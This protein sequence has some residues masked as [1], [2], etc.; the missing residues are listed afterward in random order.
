MIMLLSELLRLPRRLSGSSVSRLPVLALLAAILPIWA[1]AGS[2]A[3]AKDAPKLATNQ[4]YLE[5]INRATVL[6]TGN[7][8]AVFAFVFASLPDT[9]K[10][11]PTENYYYFTFIH[12][13]ATFT[14]N[15]RLDAAD[16]DQGFL[17][18]AYFHEY[19][20]WQ[21]GEDPAYKKLGGADG[22]RVEKR[23]KLAY[24]AEFKG[25]QVL[26]E[27]NDL[28][29]V[30]PPEGFLLANERYIGPIYDESGVQFFLV[31]NPEAKVFHYFL[32]ET[33]PSDIF[34]ASSVSERIIIGRRTGFAFYKD[35]HRERKIL[36]GVHET[37][38]TLN[39]YL[40]GPFDQLPD[41]FLQG[42]E[43]K[44]AI[45]AVQPDLAGQI[46]RFGGAAD[47][48]SRFAITPYRSWSEESDL[49]VFEEC[50]A[51]KE[52]PAGGYYACFAFDEEADEPEQ[53]ED[54]DEPSAEEKKSE[55]K[56]PP[57][58]KEQD[59]AAPRN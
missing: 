14:G 3:Q 34:A 13:G 59:K 9:V 17:H 51:K 46:D 56:Q 11:Y 37:N 47:G 20:A 4:A 19:T 36:I 53:A 33:A 32:N 21:S 45:L 16:R 5:E 29:N 38:S 15:L 2:P 7:I 22:V 26:F 6:D 44:K 40:D 55:A 50:A 58:E 48:S 42:D 1:S 57:G 18:F 23:G 31:F 54:D 25:K 24:A 35:K 52:L 49:A 30:R 28:S 12:N 10:V 8:M 41:N 27:L 43:L 39:N